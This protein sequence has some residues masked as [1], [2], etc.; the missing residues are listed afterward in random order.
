VNIRIPAV[1]E[2]ESR[3]ALPDFLGATA[4]DARTE[5]VSKRGFATHRTS[6]GKNKGD[7]RGSFEERGGFFTSVANTLTPP[8]SG[9]GPERP[10]MMG[11]D[12]SGGGLGSKDWNG[13]VVLP[14]GSY[15]HMLLVFIP[16]TT[17]TDGSLLVGIETVAPRAHSPVGYVHN[18]ASTEA[19]GNPESV[20]H[21]HKQ[22]KI[23]SGG[24]KHNERYV[25]LQELGAKRDDGN[26]RAFL[27]DIKQEWHDRLANTQDGSTER[28]AMYEELVGQRQHFYGQTE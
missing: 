9:L 28:R 8:F 24:L 18:I 17:K 6:I 15:G 5:H 21:G 3:T 4:D 12:I 10:Q 1:P 20:L 14:N 26:W 22:D 27:D 2:G 25:D 16:P 19:T 11:V 23:G 13:K 7:E